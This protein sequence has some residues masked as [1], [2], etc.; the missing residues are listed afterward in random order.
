MSKKKIE[1]ELIQFPV[2]TRDYEI[3]SL[4]SVV[5]EQVPCTL[6]FRRVGS[7]VRFGHPH[8]VSLSG[9]WSTGP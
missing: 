4:V 6:T 2:V 1:K 7:C 9:E 3:P 8:D 5:F